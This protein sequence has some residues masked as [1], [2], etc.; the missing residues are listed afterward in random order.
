ML[1]GLVIDESYAPVLLLRKARQLRYE[2]GNW[3][4]H[5]KHEEWN[6][7]LY[8]MSRKY[9]VR[10]FQLL[11]NPVCFLMC[12]Y[13]SFVYGLI[14]G[15]LFAIPIVFEQGRGWSPVI[16]SLAFIALLLGC[17]IGLAAN[18]L[19]QKLYARAMSKN[20]GKP[21]PEARLYPMMAGGFFLA[22]G[23]FIF[24]WT[25]TSDVVW[26][27]PC[28]GLVL[29]GAGFFPVFQASLNYVCFAV[30]MQMNCTDNAD[31]SSIRFSQWRLRQSRP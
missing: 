14:Y 1:A 28:I 19:N 15:S 9:L 26:V 16:G 25:G 3:A 6:V 13:A 24:G 11:V 17:V 30:W 23:L 2:T 21:V 20:G 12:F 7:S 31:R 5:A 10:P 4:L 27:V 18:T 22:T 29:I 8:E